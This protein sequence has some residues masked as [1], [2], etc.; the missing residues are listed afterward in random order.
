MPK[1]IWQLVGQQAPY[2]ESGLQLKTSRGWRFLTFLPISHLAPPT[3]TKSTWRRLDSPMQLFLHQFSFHIIIHPQLLTS[4]LFS[5]ILLFLKQCQC[6]EYYYILWPV[7]SSY[8]CSCFE[9]PKHV[10]KTLE[11]CVLC[12]NLFCIQVHSLH[13]FLSGLFSSK[14]RKKLGIHGNM[15]FFFEVYYLRCYRLKTDYCAW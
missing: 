5:Y 10:D 11:H 14:Q 6:I 8:Y 1:N 9:N 12:G 3:P 2:S 13:T 15:C 4:W 7:T